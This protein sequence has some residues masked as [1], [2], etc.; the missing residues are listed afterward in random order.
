SGFMFKIKSGI[1][2]PDTA[3][4]TGTFNIATDGTG[5]V[6]EDVAGVTITYD[7]LVLY[8]G[9]GGS[10]DE[11]CGDDADHAC[12]LQKALDK[13]PGYN[14]TIHLAAGTYDGAGD[15]FDYTSSGD[16]SLTMIGANKNTTIL[17]STTDTLDVSSNGSV[18]ISKVQ[19]N[20][21]G[22]SNQAGLWLSN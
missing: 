22:S 2:N 10:T 7:T 15:G 18:T 4:L 12:E 21:I 9:V 5:E 13:A 19:F 8:A 1:T 14:T 3:G 16:E 11:D 20:G 6:P 17:T